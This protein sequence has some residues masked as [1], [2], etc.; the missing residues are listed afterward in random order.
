MW[1][2]AW[3]GPAGDGAPVH[4]AGD[5]LGDHEVPQVVQTGTHAE[6]SREL[7]EPMRDPV[8][9]GRLAAV[10]GLG[11]HIGV[12]GQARPGGQ[13]GLDLAHTIGLEQLSGVAA[14]RHA[15]LGMGFGVLVDQ[16][17]SCHSDHAAGDE[18]LAVIEVNIT[19]LEATQLPP[20]RTKYH[21]EAQEQT[22]LRVLVHRHLQ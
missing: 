2:S 16:R 17:P 3:P 21:G 14:D 12:W 9:A 11:E 4:A 19:P 6:T 1:P 10:L 22:E 13:C 8:G 15:A 7:L 18:D 5:E 20:A